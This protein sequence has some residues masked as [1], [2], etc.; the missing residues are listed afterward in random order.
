MLVVIALGDSAIVH[1][2]SP[3]DTHGLRQSIR[4]AASNIANIARQ[5]QV[6]LLHG[7]GP[8]I[9]LLT[10]M[11]GNCTDLNTGAADVLGAQTRA[12]IGFLL[13]QELR[14]QLPEQLFCSMK[15]LTLVDANDPALMNPTRYAGPLFN[16]I[17]A[18]L[19]QEQNPDWVLKRDNRHFRRVIA[20]PE[21]KEI[22]EMVTLQHLVAHNK[23]F[24]ICGC[25]GG[26][27][28]RRCADN[29]LHGVDAMVDRDEAAALVAEGIAADA[30]LMLSCIDAVFDRFGQPEARAIRN[31]TVDTLRSL[32]FNDMAMGPKAKAAC[33]FV[34]D[35]QK[36]CAI[37]N[38]HNAAE[39]LAGKAGTQISA[40]G[41]SSSETAEIVYY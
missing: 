40:S 15:H 32:D 28:V 6:V 7:N 11:N 20:A 17:Q 5:H 18:Q 41:V 8:E 3:L 14:S 33:Q 12:M 22:L 31:I 38:L 4:S 19:I 34:K 2:E 21:P 39:V 27:P 29:N 36:I 37:G 24:V 25:G 13:E 1:R 16:R 23:M 9:G 30:L 10:L 35:S 26:L